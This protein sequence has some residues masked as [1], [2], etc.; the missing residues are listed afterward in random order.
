MFIIFPPPPLRQVVRVHI[1]PPP[2]PDG[3]MVYNVHYFLWCRLSHQ[4]QG[5]V[6]QS[7]QRRCVQNSYCDAGVY[8]T[9]IVTQV[10]TVQ[11][12][13]LYNKGGTVF[14]ISFHAGGYRIKSSLYNKTGCYSVY[15]F[16][17]RRWI[18]CN[19]HHFIIRQVGTVF[20]ISFH[21]GGYRI[22]SS[23]YNKTGCYSVYHFLSRR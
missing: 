18:Q 23:L 15:R 1:I 7:L 5:S 4:R 14:T 8:K 10:D 17:S 12:S 9:V 6:H 20:T 3:R 11:L 22:K 2:H 21:A 13:S 16:L 19:C